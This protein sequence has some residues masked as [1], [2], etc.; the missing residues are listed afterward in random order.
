MSVTSGTWA[1]GVFT[2]CALALP[3][4]AAAQLPNSYNTPGAATK[5]NAKQ[6]CAADY[7]TAVKPVANWQ[8]NAAL[9]RYGIRPESFNGELDHLV[10]VALGGSNDPENL[11][12]IHSAGDMTPAAKARLAEKLKAMVCDGKMSLKDAQNAFKKD[13]TKAYTQYATAL[14]APGGL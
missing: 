12:P 10:P 1:R 3:A 5:A 13:W 7:A 9:E 11:W 2:A 14:N 6:I 8:K 4:I